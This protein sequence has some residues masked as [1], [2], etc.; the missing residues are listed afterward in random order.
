MS[1]QSV[2][3]ADLATGT[4]RLDPSRSSVEFHVPSFYGLVTVHGRFDRYEGALSMSGRPAVALTIEADSLD[5]DNKRRDTHLRSDDFF[6]AARHPWVRFEA[7]DAHLDGETL[8][9][10]GVLHA[11]GGNVPLEIDAGVTAVG[12]EFEIEASALVDQRRL[13]MTFSAA[14]LVR[15]PTRLTVRGRLVRTE[16]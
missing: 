10:R 16:D 7:D 2:L 5:T 15:A 12:E 13:G 1:T 6:G 9:V 4:W 11:A 3:T 8:N 14:G